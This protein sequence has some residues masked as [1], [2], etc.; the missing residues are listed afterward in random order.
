MSATT[1]MTVTTVK[2]VTTVMTVTMFI[3]EIQLD[4]RG[5]LDVQVCITNERRQLSFAA[6]F[7]AMPETVFDFDVAPGCLGSFI[8]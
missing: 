3:N 2:T 8:A 7:C 5:I 1:V 6:I 4:I